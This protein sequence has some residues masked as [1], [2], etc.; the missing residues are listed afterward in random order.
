MGNPPRADDEGDDDEM[1][2]SELLGGPKQR[3]DKDILGKAKPM[4]FAGTW[5]GSCA[6][7]AH[8]VVLLIDGSTA[9]AR[10]M[11][12]VGLVAAWQA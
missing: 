8:V 5:R 1:D 11:L 4:P 2:L 6:C 9:G 12:D 10:A 3:K 7:P